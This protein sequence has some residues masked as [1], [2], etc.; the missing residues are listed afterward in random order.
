MLW[1]V[2]AFMTGAT[3]FCAL[4]PLSRGASGASGRDKALAFHQ[5]QLAEIDRDVE[6]GQ[7]P[8]DQAGAARAEAARRLIAA[9]DRDAPVAD[10]RTDENKIAMRNRRRVA[11][12]FIM[13]FVPVATFALYSKLGNP[14]LED[15]PLLSR[16]N[17]PNNPNFLEASVATIEKHLAA[18]PEDGRGYLVI[19]PAYMRLQ[20][21]DDAA[22]AYAQALRLNGENAETRADYGEALVSAANGIVTAPAR[23]AFERSYADNPNLPKSR[24]YLGLAAEQAG[25]KATAIRLYQS[26]LDDD[27]PLKEMWTAPLHQRLALLGAQARAATSETAPAAAPDKAPA[28]PTNVPAGEAAAIASMDAKSQQA[29]IRGMVDNLAARLA[30][31]GDD[32]PGWL[33]LIRAWH[34][35]QDD[36]KAR[37]AL[38]DARKALAGHADAAPALDALA[39]EIGI[40]S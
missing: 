31:N 8:P 14:E 5:A 9:A 32:Q 12:A 29:A 30:Q 37:A 24:V 22:R 39:R 18:A 13:V 1:V 16:A 25:D 26:V 10:D 28:L 2:F 11:A 21:Y 3:V 15:Q 23:A 40:G 17:D 36:D 33:R 7:L 38:A 4:W 34:V 35:L 6:R 20:R 19:A 27:L